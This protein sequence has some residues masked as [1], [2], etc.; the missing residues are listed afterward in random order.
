VALLC[1]SLQETC[2]LLQGLLCVSVSCKTHCQAS[3]EG[4]EERKKERKKE[5]EREGDNEVKERVEKWRG[6]QCDTTDLQKEKI[7]EGKLK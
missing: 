4:G 5:G 7:K 6:Q 1:L 3:V 2:E